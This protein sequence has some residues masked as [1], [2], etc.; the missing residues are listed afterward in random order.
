MNTPMRWDVLQL[1]TLIVI[2]LMALSMCSFQAGQTVGVVINEHKLATAVAR[3]VD[4]AIELK[5]RAR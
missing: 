4:E 5:W 2:V 1:G 3:Q